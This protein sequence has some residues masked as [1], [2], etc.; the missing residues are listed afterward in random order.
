MKSYLY[1]Y[2]KLEHAHITKVNA[3]CESQARS[4][5]FMKLRAEMPR[6]EAFSISEDALMLE[7]QEVCDECGEYGCDG[8]ECLL[9]EC[10]HCRVSS[11]IVEFSGDNAMLECGHFIAFR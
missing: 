7:E 11:P 2:E 8:R 6:E 5:L 1:A 9:Q 3:T 4:F 10:P